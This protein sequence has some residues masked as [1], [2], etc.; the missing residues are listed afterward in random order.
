MVSKVK[1]KEVNGFRFTMETSF[2]FEERQ[3]ENTLRKLE[4]A[5]GDKQLLTIRNQP[6]INERQFMEFVFGDFVSGDTKSSFLLEKDGKE[7]FKCEY[8][9]DKE[10]VL[11]Y[12]DQ[13]GSVFR[14][15]KSVH[16]AHS[17]L[18]NIIVPNLLGRINKEVKES[19]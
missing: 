14:T 16:D 3:Y 4:Q 19:F 11:E 2:E 15:V 6:Y 7:V 13:Y 5:F 18:R 9:Y 10:A 8:I 17:F 12:K 1:T